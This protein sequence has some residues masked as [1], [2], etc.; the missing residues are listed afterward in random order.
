MIIDKR[1]ALHRVGEYEK[2]QE[3]DK[4]IDLQREGLRCDLDSLN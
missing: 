1:L 4:S 2:S 3:K